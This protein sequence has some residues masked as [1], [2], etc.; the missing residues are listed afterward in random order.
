MRDSSACMKAPSEES[1]ANEPKKHY[2]QKYIQLLTTL[3]L[4]MVV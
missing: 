2:V 3:S 1:M 4:T